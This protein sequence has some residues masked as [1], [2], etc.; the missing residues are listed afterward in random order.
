LLES[1]TK[2][3]IEP[4]SIHVNHTKLAKKPKQ[5]LSITDVTPQQFD[6]LSKQIQK[7]YKIT[8]AKRLS[9]NSKEKLVQDTNLIYS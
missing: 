3:K 4:F 1:I 5:F 9:E 2:A 6:F 8:K 7:K